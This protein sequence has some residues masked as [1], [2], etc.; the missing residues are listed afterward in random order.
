MSQALSQCSAWVQMQMRGS[1]EQSCRRQRS[2]ACCER[3]A[4]RRS[5]CCDV[6]SNP[7]RRRCRRMQR[8]SPPQSRVLSRPRPPAAGRSPSG[9][10]LQRGSESTAEIRGRPACGPEQRVGAVLVAGLQV[11]LPKPGAVSAF[12]EQGRQGLHVAGR[13]ETSARPKELPVPRVSHFFQEPRAGLRPS[14]LECL[15]LDF[16]LYIIY[17][18]ILIKGEG[19]YLNPAEP[20]NNQGI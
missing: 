8:S 13:R 11:P 5:F 16:S 10:H 14:G 3:R 1:A 12:A 7:C 17:L 2:L 15:R 4:V 19:R 20:L 9:P 18:S 6:G